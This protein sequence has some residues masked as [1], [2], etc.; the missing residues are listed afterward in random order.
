MRVAVFTR[1]PQQADKPRGGVEAVAVVLIRALSRLDDL[2]V[3]VVTLESGR[4]TIEV[5]QDGQAT[6]HRLPGSRWPQIVDILVGPGKKQ[7]VR[8]LKELKPDVLHT[9]ETHGLG[10]GNLP[11][12]HVF[13]VHGFDDQNLIADSAGL[14]RLRS[15]LWRLVQ[16]YGLARQKSIISIAPYVRRMIEPLTCAEIYDIDNP[17]DERF[18]NITRSEEAGRILCVGWINERKNTLGSVQALARV[19]KKGVQ[20]TLAIAGTPKEQAYYQRVLTCIRENGLETRVELLGHIGHDRLAEELARSSVLLLP[21]R[22]ENS[23]MAIAEAMA[24]GLPVIASNRCGMPYMVSEG[25][26]GFL[27]EPDDHAQ[28]ADRLMQ[29]LGN[30]GLRRQMGEEGRRIAMARFYPDAVARQTQAVY[31]KTCLTASARG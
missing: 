31:E 20:A 13:T 10:L 8:Y 22:Q 30:P 14:A 18:F 4:S 21:S 28:I 7:L 26:S 17:V 9:H 12:P 16:R 5:T 2:E 1:Y 6:I 24:V 29:V 11:I 19:V 23:P 15:P 3:H 25:Q 27:I